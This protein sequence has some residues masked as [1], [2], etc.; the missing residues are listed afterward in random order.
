MRQRAFLALVSSLLLAPPCTGNPEEQAQST[1]NIIDVST[2]SFS[3]LDVGKDQSLYLDFSKSDT[4]NISGNIQNAGQIFAF[5]TVP[6][7]A[8]TIAGNNITN[9]QGGLISTILS[10]QALQALGAVSSLSL[11][12]ASRGDINN[13]GLISSSADLSVLAAGAINNIS[14]SSNLATFSA[15]NNLNIVTSALSNNGAISALGTINVGNQ[16]NSQIIQQNSIVAS[17]ANSLTSNNLIIQSTLGS[18][19]A[20][21]LNFRLSGS[22]NEQGVLG[23]FGGN[24]SGNIEAHAPHGTL[25]I[26]ANR[27]DGTL[28]SSA[29]SVFAGVREGHLHLGFSEVEGDPVYWNYT[30][31]MTLSGAI[32]VPYTEQLRFLSSGNI[33]G[34]GVTKISGGAVLFGTGM[35]F[36]PPYPGD[37]PAF[38]NFLLA[39][40]ASKAFGGYTTN[41]DLLGPIAVMQNGT[42]TVDFSASPGVLIESGSLL[43]ISAGSINFP[44]SSTLK[45][46]N[47]V[48]LRSTGAISVGNVSAPQIAMKA[49]GGPITIA[50]AI[51]VD[52]P[53]ISLL[54]ITSAQDVS[55][56]AGSSVSYNGKS[57]SSF[58]I[59]AEGTNISSQG[60]SFTSNVPMLF[61]GNTGIDFSA[62]SKISPSLQAILTAKSGVVNMGTTILDGTGD[63][64]IN[65]KYNGIVNSPQDRLYSFVGTG[66][67]NG[68]TSG[69]KAVTAGQATIAG[70]GNLLASAVKNNTLLSVTPSQKNSDSV[71]RFSDS[72]MDFRDIIQRIPPPPPNSTI[73]KTD[74]ISFLSQ[75]AMTIVE[76]LF[77]SAYAEEQNAYMD[78]IQHPGYDVFYG[79]LKA[80]LKTLD[81]DIPRLENERDRYRSGFPN[82]VFD[83]Q[84][85]MDRLNSLPPGEAVSDK[86][87]LGNR[88]ETP[89]E[90]AAQLE[91]RN[92]IIERLKSK[93]ESLVKLLGNHNALL[94]AFNTWKGEQ[95]Q[96]ADSMKAAAEAQAEA[97][98]KAAEAKALKDVDKPKPSLGDK[99]K[100]YLKRIENWMPPTSTL[101]PES[102]YRA[103]AFSESYDLRDM[104]CSIISVDENLDV[105]VRGLHL[106]L[107]K[108]S[109]I[110]L[111]IH[112]QNLVL[113]NFYDNKYGDVTITTNLKNFKIA[114]GE[115]V[116]F[117]GSSADE[118]HALNRGS[119][120]AV[121][122]TK[123]L[124]R[125]PHL[126]IHSAEF[127][128]LSALTS[129]PE[130]QKVVS[131]SL[132]SDTILKNRL[133]KTAAC[134]SISR[135]HKGAYQYSRL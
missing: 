83:S 89:E 62:N 27:I 14:Q 44:N 86:S 55:F 37:N 47:I 113:F 29:Q 16:L 24:F 120:I 118:F 128:V 107:R 76:L 34:T 60:A 99:I 17:I 66:S 65:G 69:L 64:V 94:R 68:D 82:I 6:L 39:A 71:P 98:K 4:L 108:G 84:L 90:F 57:G 93:Q 81:S 111:A 43:G 91:K 28:N 110:G 36:A 31:D 88:P 131:S 1:T 50:G 51:V 45:A 92:A 103:I 102:I 78:M 74:E 119:K 12:I 114:P 32:T 105:S 18:F 127:S 21:D 106:V 13:A 122:Q 56:L 130:L 49:D 10:P 40:G 133:L 79:S 38:D 75:G 73:L 33:I 125:S 96:R 3:A 67:I 121:R 19:R 72:V 5:S 7:A 123:V 30:G 134:L 100:D 87:E 63:L 15:A 9:G 135:A 20:A 124:D 48:D 53:P 115:Q 59:R 77:P 22:P 42:G 95:Q 109:L 126:A 25:M 54:Q 132:A 26:D 58:E 104:P 112:N 70:D 101:G 46:L 35:T 129:I 85:A 2:A 116:I 8:V 80:E 23:V 11:Q 41:N 52:S 61:F 97:E 117:S